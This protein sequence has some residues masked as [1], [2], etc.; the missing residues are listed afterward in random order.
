MEWSVILNVLFG[1]GLVA[2]IVGLL[3]IRS[4]L[5]KARAE[6]EKA[7]AEADTVKITNTENATR[8]LMENIVEPLRGELNA[9]RTELNETREELK[10]VPPLKREVTRLRKAMEAVQ[11][12]DYHDVCP[13]LDELQNEVGGSVIDSPLGQ[14]GHSV[15]YRHRLGKHVGAKR[16]G[17]H[18]RTSADAAADRQ[19]ADRCGVQRVDPSGA[20]ISSEVGGRDAE[21][22][23]TGSEFGEGDN[24]RP[25]EP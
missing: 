22:L 16:S 20:C 13:V 25:C 9:T 14:S 10:Q 21:P 5:K 8:I 6:A 18:S 7:V 24:E 23:C 1:T 11:R 17:H 2:T 3:S 19:S 4:E 12:C 15:A